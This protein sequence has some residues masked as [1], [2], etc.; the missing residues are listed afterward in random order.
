MR[1]VPFCISPGPSS[2]FNLVDDD[3]SLARF[4]D[5]SKIPFGGWPK[6]PPLYRAQEWFPFSSSGHWKIRAAFFLVLVIT[7]PLFFFLPPPLPV[8]VHGPPFPSSVNTCIWTV[9]Y[10]QP[11][12]FLIRSLISPDLFYSRPS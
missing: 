6:N 7:F 1:R 10:W 8:R 4:P 11:P 12:H 3:F 2:F 5:F 9:G